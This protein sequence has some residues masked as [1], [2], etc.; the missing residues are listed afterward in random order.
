[1]SYNSS[2]KTAD[3]VE[4]WNHVPC[5]C[6]EPVLLFKVLPMY[7]RLTVLVSCS[8]LVY[9]SWTA[10]SSAQAAKYTTRIATIIYCEFV[11]SYQNCYNR[12]RSFT[13]DQ[14]PRL[15]ITTC[16]LDSY[17][18]I[19]PFLFTWRVIINLQGLLPSKNATIGFDIHKN[20]EPSISECW[21]IYDHT[22]N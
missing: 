5:R 17:L 20:Q 13:S 12:N 21:M 2:N 18:Y 15:T 10:L 8:V 9:A 7:V 14:E 11:F 22:F 4:T 16:R 3:C 19:D 6:A 1:M